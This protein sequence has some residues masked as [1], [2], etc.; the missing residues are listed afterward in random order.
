MK[1][2][3]YNKPIMTLPTGFADLKVI[4]NKEHTNLKIVNRNKVGVRVLFHEPQKLTIFEAELL[5]DLYFL[6]RR[7]PDYANYHKCKAGKKFIAN[8][9]SIS[10]IE[11][12]NTVTVYKETVIKREED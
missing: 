9:K 8:I 3:N 10:K 12:D 7:P 6:N 2:L 4:T 1:Q 11:I 5:Y